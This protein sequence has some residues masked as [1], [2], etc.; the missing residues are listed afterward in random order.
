MGEA[1]EGEAERAPD[2]ILVVSARRWF[3]S[4][5][6]AVLE[7]EGFSVTWVRSG[8]E[9]LRSVSK[10]RPALVL[11]D[12]GLADLRQIS[13]RLSV[14]DRAR[15]PEADDGVDVPTSTRRTR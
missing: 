5:L 3:A 9:A 15:N 12:E 7:P 14:A 13:C 1:A 6:E 4:A 8:N 11:I 2:G 10:S